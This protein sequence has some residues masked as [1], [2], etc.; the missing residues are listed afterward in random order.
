MAVSV[1]MDHHIYMYMC[2]CVCVC[3]CA[4]VAWNSQKK[5]VKKTPQLQLLYAT[6][7]DEC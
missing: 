6:T 4:C 1:F 7:T 5:K 3:V 2:V